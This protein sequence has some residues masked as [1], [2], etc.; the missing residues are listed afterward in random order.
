MSVFFPGLALSAVSNGLVLLVFKS[1]E[2]VF[3]QKKVFFEG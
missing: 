2:I 1:C 3:K